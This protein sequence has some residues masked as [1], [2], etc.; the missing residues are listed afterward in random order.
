MA[1][2][3]TEATFVDKLMLVPH[4]AKIIT[5]V[6]IRLV[7]YPLVAITGGTKA[8]MMLKDIAFTGLR[9]H[10]GNLNTA[11][12]IFLL[13]PSTEATYLE[14]AKK[15]GFQPDSDVLDSGMKVH[16]LGNKSAEKVLVFF[17]GG[18][19][20]VPATEQHLIWYF[21]LSKDLSKKTKLSVIMPSYTL[22]PQG[23][24]PLQ[25]QQAAETLDFLINKQGKKPSD[26]FISGDS[27]GGNMT[28]SLMS[29]LFHPHP[30]VSKID[31]KEPLAGAVLLSPWVSFNTNT[32][33]WKQFENSDMLAVSA[34][35]R[36]ASQFLGDRSADNYVEAAN[37]DASWWSGLDKVVKDVI[38]WGGGA[39]RLLDG[40]NEF[41]NK[42]KSAHKNT[43]IVI[44]PGAAHDDFIAD[45]FLG[46]KEKSEATKVVESWIAERI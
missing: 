20:A 6:C 33:S 2:H 22:S 16:W 3:R 12:E 11:Q 19:Y 15:Q 23:Q 25:L 13:P 8:N 34:V 37:A 45:V 32:R 35:E 28:V 46:K 43:E 38:I 10:M 9:T 30:A 1:P 24:Y 17:H 5:A 31:L 27:A 26:I 39:E 4:I 36:W 7:T 42:L 18:G 21:N 29:H 14:F 40:I 41:A 44:E